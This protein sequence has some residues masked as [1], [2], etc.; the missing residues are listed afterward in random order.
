MKRLLCCVLFSILLTQGVCHAG[1]N[2]PPP[3][4]Y[5]CGWTMRQ[6]TGIRDQAFNLAL[7]WLVLPH[8]SPH[9]GAVVV[10]HRR[11]KAL[12]GGAGGHVAQIVQ[13]Q[14]HC[15]ALVR[16]DKGTYSRDICSRLA[17]YVEAGGLNAQANATGTRDTGM[18][19]VSAGK[20]RHASSSRR[21]DIPRSTP[22][23]RAKGAAF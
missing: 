4:G 15:R 6:I 11:G 1:T 3:H 19:V 5:R 14:G 20:H 8:T 21:A 22:L 7:H 18:H 23:D 12:G 2:T 13:M 16:D 9:P 17:G 10:F